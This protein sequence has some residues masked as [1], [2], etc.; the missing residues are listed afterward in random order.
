MDCPDSIDPDTERGFAHPDATVSAA[1]LQ[2]TI[3]ETA[4]WTG[5]E[6]LFVLAKQPDGAPPLEATLAGT[7]W[8]FAANATVDAPG[9]WKW[10]VGEGEIPADGQLVFADTAIGQIALDRWS[11]RPI[12]RRD[13]SLAGRRTYFKPDYGPGPVAD[14]TWDQLRSLVPKAISSGGGTTADRAHRLGNWVLR[15]WTYRN[16][17]SGRTYAPWHAPTI[18]EW[19][20]RG[21]A[22][23]GQPV[24]AMCV[25]F[26]VVFQQL[27][28]TMGI[29]ARL[30]ALCPGLNLP[31]GHFVSE[32]WLAEE[33]RWALIDANLGLSFDS[34]SRKNLSL[35]EIANL[36]DPRACARFAAPDLWSPANAA[37]AVDPATYRHI[38]IWARHDFLS[39]PENAPPGHGMVP[40]SETDILWIDAPPNVTPLAPFPG[41]L[42]PHAA[43]QPPTPQELT[44]L[45]EL[46]SRHATR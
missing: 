22:P 38:G 16:A 14:T 35:L 8:S 3:P 42:T 32:V 25:H 43:A 40:Y 7:R 1:G 17:L 27:A 33:S 12:V 9:G 28:L 20:R 44:N 37:F 6:R 21:H 31:S 18:L 23:D 36:P 15:Q 2:L 45:H 11:G 13:Y 24:I 19:G 34:G 10:L 46:S 5:W 4:R 30:I 29:P 41:G 39:R 26:A